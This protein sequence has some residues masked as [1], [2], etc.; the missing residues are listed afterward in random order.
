MHFILP[1]EKNKATYPKARYYTIYATPDAVPCDGAVGDSLVSAVPDA[2]PSCGLFAVSEFPRGI[3]MEFRL[4]WML[5]SCS[6]KLKSGGSLF[7]FG[8][9]VFGSLSSLKN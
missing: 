3:K 1:R 8:R 9:R 7:P 5:N 2:P 6:V 4:G